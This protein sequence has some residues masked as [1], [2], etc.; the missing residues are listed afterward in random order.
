M[1]TKTAQL[2]PLVKPPQYRHRN[3]SSGKLKGIKKRRGIC[4][5]LGFRGW[6]L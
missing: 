3:V 6:K 1:T 4:V 5:S 2:E